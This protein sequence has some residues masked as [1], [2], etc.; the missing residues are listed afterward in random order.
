MILKQIDEIFHK[1]DVFFHHNLIGIQGNQVTIRK[2]MANSD[3]L[4]GTCENR[5]YLEENT[6]FCFCGTDGCNGG[7]HVVSTWTTIF[8]VICGVLMTITMQ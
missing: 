4:V 8:L 1:N 3:H 2:C 6:K 7:H 5:H